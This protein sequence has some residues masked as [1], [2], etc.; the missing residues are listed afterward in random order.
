MCVNEWKWNKLAI[1]FSFTREMPQRRRRRLHLQFTAQ[2]NKFIH[3][4]PLDSLAAPILII[5]IVEHNIDG[6]RSAE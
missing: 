2:F 1:D 3:L 5:D 6:M 4:N